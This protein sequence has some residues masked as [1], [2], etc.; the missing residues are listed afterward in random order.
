MPVETPQR[1]SARAFS[2]P[3]STSSTTA[4]GE[5]WW[6]A[7]TLRARAALAAGRGDARQADTPLRA[8]LDVARARR[9][10]IFELKSALALARPLRA[11]RRVA[12]ALQVLS[13]AV[14]RERGEGALPLVAEARE[15]EASPKA[16]RRSMLDVCFRGC[17]GG[18]P[19]SGKHDR[20]VG[21]G[22]LYAGNFPG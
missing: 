12:D 21:T 7:E 19:G 13:G 14:R 11:R 16:G 9:A 10:G 22:A 18:L 20:A 1:V 2:A 3:V 15:L 5:E 17:A 6:R 8:A 4:F